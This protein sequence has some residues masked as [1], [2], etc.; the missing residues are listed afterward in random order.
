MR[1]S[2]TRERIPAEKF[3]YHVLTNVG[4]I[5]QRTSYIDALNRQ[6]F[7]WDVWTPLH[8][9]F[10]ELKIKTKECSHY[11]SEIFYNSLSMKMDMQYVLLYAGSHAPLMK[12]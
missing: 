12:N 1:K 11:P 10:L 2:K 7:Q 4:G 5:T 3:H 8:L 6:G 9:L